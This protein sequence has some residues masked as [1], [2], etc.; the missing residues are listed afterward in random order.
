VL[1]VFWGLTVTSLIFW[2]ALYRCN[3]L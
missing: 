1:Y 3:V 2:S